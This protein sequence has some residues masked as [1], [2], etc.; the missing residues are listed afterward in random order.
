[1]SVNTRA[2]KI[3]FEV[4]VFINAVTRVAMIISPHNIIA[5][6]AAILLT[7]FE[8]FIIIYLF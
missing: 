7:F 1:M 5:V 4:S 2:L 6:R 3:L 8:I